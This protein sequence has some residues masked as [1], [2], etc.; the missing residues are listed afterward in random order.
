MPDTPNTDREFKVGDAV[1][2]RAS[3]YEGPD[4]HSPGGYYAMVGE[5]LIVRSVRDKGHWPISVSHE[6]RTDGNSFGV[7]A[8]EIQ[9]WSVP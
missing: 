2:P 5:K 6:D 8:E 7:S 4:D 3:I 1:T 9:P